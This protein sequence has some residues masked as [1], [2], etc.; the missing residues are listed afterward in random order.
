MGVEPIIAYVAILA[1]A[2]LEPAAFQIL[3]LDGLPIAYCAIN[4]RIPI[5]LDDP[6]TA[7]RVS[8]LGFSGR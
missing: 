2:G 4:D 5:P 1:Q 8:S 3:S 6:L 7:E